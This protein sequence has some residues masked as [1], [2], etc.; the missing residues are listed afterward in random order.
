VLKRESGD[1]F[2]R[3]VLD[4]TRLFGNTVV[5]DV[6]RYFFFVGKGGERTAETFD[7]RVVEILVISGLRGLDIK[8]IEIRGRISRDKLVF[9]QTLLRPPNKHGPDCKT[10]RR[11]ESLR[12][13][14]RVDDNGY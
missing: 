13:G 11:N 7:K 10:T 6:L 9:S 3:D 14:R 4:G 2:R 12:G 1:W 8:Q 5:E